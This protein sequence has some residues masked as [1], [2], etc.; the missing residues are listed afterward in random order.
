M[1]GSSTSGKIFK[2]MVVILVQKLKGFYQHRVV[3]WVHGRCRG[4]AAPVAS[5]VDPLASSAAD[6]GP[7]FGAD[8]LGFPRECFPSAAASFQEAYSNGRPERSPLNIAVLFNSY[9]YIVSSNQNISIQQPLILF[10]QRQ[11]FIQFFFY[12]QHFLKRNNE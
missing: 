2:Y 5:P 7:R 11:A 9:T 3:S 1:E 4:C 10:Q 6:H 8:L 12:K